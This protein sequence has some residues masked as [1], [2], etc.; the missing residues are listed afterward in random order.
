MPGLSKR[1]TIGTI[2]LY[3]KYKGENYS[4]LKL[5]YE[6]TS[7]IEGEVIFF[8]NYFL[9]VKLCVFHF[10]QCVKKKKKKDSL[11]KLSIKLWIL[12]QQIG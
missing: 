7:N 4:T 8:H 9:L 6:T 2:Y 12:A 3:T 11:K 5:G 10:K 1:V